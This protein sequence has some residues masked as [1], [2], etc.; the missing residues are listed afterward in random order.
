[1]KIEKRSKLKGGGHPF[2]I[3]LSLI[4][5]LIGIALV[6]HGMNGGTLGSGMVLAI[7]LFVTIKEILDIFH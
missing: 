1:M 4:G 7:G 5:V 3:V 6:L 2:F